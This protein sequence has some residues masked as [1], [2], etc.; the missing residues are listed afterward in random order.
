MDQEETDQAPEIQQAPGQLGMFDQVEEEAH[1]GD[2]S[3]PDPLIEKA[4]DLFG[5]EN[6]VVHYDDK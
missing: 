4:V 6:V 3:T 2:E 5:Q 1:E